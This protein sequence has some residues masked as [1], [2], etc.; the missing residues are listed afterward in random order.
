LQDERDLV[1][2]LRR[3]SASLPD[4]FANCLDNRLELS[5]L[6]VAIGGSL[7]RHRVQE[8]QV[9]SQVDTKN[10]MLPCL[11]IKNITKTII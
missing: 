4:L 9:P 1:T 5:F 7:A 8:K 10:I 6:P 3:P 11:H 2:E